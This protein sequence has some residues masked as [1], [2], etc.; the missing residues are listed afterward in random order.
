[1]S[2]K[3][4]NNNMGEKQQKQKPVR[5]TTTTTHIICER[6]LTRASASFRRNTVIVT[7]LQNKK[8]KQNLNSNKTWKK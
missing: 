6:G 2:E 7:L 5:K 4:K 3:N 8:T 1:L